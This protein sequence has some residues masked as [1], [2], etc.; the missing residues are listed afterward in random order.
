MSGSD[1]TESWNAGA[2]AA[3][4][5]WQPEHMDPA[6]ICYPR[7]V[8][9]P[10]GRSC[11]CMQPLVQARWTFKRH[12]PDEDGNEAHKDCTENEGPA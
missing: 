11:A 7:K 1:L 4:V 8:L 9:A 10:L 2:E 12:L 3:Q 6:L 5:T